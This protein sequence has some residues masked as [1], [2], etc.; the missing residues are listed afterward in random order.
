MRNSIRSRLT[1]A[2]IGLAV[3]PLLLI[4]IVLAWQSFTTQQQQALTL[5]QEVARRVSS[6]VTAFFAE[7]EN[8]LRVVSQVQGLQNLRR[9]QQQEV[10]SELLAQRNAYEELV[11]LDSRGKELIHLARVG[12]FT[13]LGERAQADEFVAPYTSGQ[14]Y[15]SPIRFDETT[16]EPFMTIALPLF[17]A[18]SGLVDG[19]LVSEVRI[20]RIWDLIAE[21]RVSQG[22]SV[23]IVDAQDAVVAHRNPSVVLKGTRLSSGNKSST[24]SPS[25]NGTRRWRSPSTP[26]SSLGS[27][28]WRR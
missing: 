28:S 15:Y 27:L 8:E 21:I 17:D 10:L 20:K 24:S 5:Q 19:V 14:V 18:R 11:L 2:F 26:C 16:G 1:L 23:Y 25:R 13:D 9:D 12:I 4:G 3:G 6:Q 7:L 22:Q